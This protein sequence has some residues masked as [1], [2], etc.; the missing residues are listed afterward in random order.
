MVDFVTNNTD[1]SKMSDDT[2]FDLEDFLPYLLN[3]AAEETSVAFQKHYKDRYGLLRTDW[4]VLFHL[5]RFGRMTATE[6]GQNARIHKTK[7]SR[8]V[9]NL[10][11]R[12]Y[13]TRETDDGDR[14]VEHLAL[15][16]AGEQV[17]RD[18][19]GFA[20]KHDRETAALFTARET[21]V[22]RKCL[23]RLANME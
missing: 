14:R 2:G 4:R 8:A 19:S 23:R 3:R 12:R 21:E 15:T 6:I 11:D 5:G 9:R 7:I 16:R 13:I 20:Q 10:A 22:L 18:L 1:T 17:Y